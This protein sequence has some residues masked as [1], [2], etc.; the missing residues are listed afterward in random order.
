MTTPREFNEDE[1]MTTTPETL[2]FQERTMD[3]RRKSRVQDRRRTERRRSAEKNDFVS[4]LPL[5]GPP[6]TWM[7]PPR[8]PKCNLEL[9]GVM[10]YYCAQIDCPTG[11]GGP[12]C[13]M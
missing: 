7:L 6:P 12:K 10:G 2:R 4:P 1:A 5:P 11:L 8:C 9:S 13:Q 3:D